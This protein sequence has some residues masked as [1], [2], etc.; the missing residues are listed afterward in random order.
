MCKFLEV[1]RNLV[2]YYL[3]KK[4]NASSKEKVLI[5]EH[6]KEIFRLNKKNY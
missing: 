5:E 2:Y 3:N 4:P 1:S 6:I